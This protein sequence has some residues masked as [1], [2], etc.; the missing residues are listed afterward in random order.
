MHRSQTRPK[1]RSDISESNRSV[2]R[3]LRCRIP[4]LLARQR[5]GISVPLLK[6]LDGCLGRQSA[7]GSRLAL[8]TVG[9]A[10]DGASATLGKSDVRAS[11]AQLSGRVATSRARQRLVIVVSDMLENS[12]ITSFYSK[13]T[14]RRI[15]PQTELAKAT[16]AGAIADFGG[17]RVFVAGAALIPDNGYRG[18]VELNAL[19]RFWQ[20]WFQSAKAKLVEFGRPNLLNPV[21]R[22]VPGPL[23]GLRG[24]RAEAVAMAPSCFRAAGAAT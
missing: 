24:R 9:K 17:A 15:D 21:S 16:A 10:V 7:Y 20:L 13:R 6:K 8:A 22:A 5:D 11:L 19:Q 4:D 3:P 23:T 1:H 18:E 12:S 14:L 2:L